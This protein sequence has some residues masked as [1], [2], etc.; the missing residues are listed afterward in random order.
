[1]YK[2]QCLNLAKNVFE[3]T[4]LPTFLDISFI[5]DV[6]LRDGSIAWFVDDVMGL[7][8]LPY[9][10]VANLDVYGR[11]VKIQVIGQNGYSRI[12]RRDEFVIMY[13]NLGRV[14]L[15]LDIIQYSERLALI[16]RTMDINIWQQRTPR[17]W[18]VP[19]EKE[20][21]LKR[22]L[23]QIDGMEETIVTYDDINLDDTTS[24]LNPAPYVSDKLDE[25]FMQ[26]W[27]EF[28]RLIGVANMSY[29]KRERNISDEVTAMQGGTI[30]SRYSRYNAR[31]Q[32]IEEIKNKFNIEIGLRYYDNLPT[33]LKESEVIEDDD[34]ESSVDTEVA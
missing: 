22:M 27:N 30:A 2:N 25:R 11:P 26:E 32:A 23:N 16:K 29:V 10:S 9:V 7:L 19:Q 33:N 3:F 12:L 21:S 4:D 24:V 15:M 18:K 8:A 5:N 20:L 34:M 31:L 1:M 6:L 14:P 28:L 13:D 17:H